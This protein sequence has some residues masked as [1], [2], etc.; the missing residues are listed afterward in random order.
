MAA[1]HVRT[2]AAGRWF[3]PSGQIEIASTPTHAAELDEDLTRTRSL[4][5]RAERIT[6]SQ[7][8]SYEPALRLPEP[9]QLI[10]RYPDE[11]YCLPYLL[12]GE[13]STRLQAAG[14]ELREGCELVSAT[15]TSAGVELRTSDGESFVADRLVCAAGRWSEQLTARLAARDGAVDPMPLL[16]CEGRDLPTLGFLGITDP[17][18]ADLRG[19][20]I[21][22][23]LSVRPEG[24]GRLMLQALDLDAAADSA[25]EP[26]PDSGI[27]REMT[28]RMTALLA[29]PRPVRLS[30]LLLGRRAIPV[31]GQTVAGWLEPDQRIYGVVTHSG[32]TLA[33]ILGD[34][35]GNEVLGLPAAELES[36]RPQR[37][38]AGEAAAS[39][40]A[41]RTPGTQ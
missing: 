28:N 34:L 22:S 7:L 24:G 25:A 4:G 2:A 15:V 16:S 33:L 8:S 29:H 9:P 21:T 3:F 35:V 23:R 36:F 27:A 11:G 6:R 30:R 1:Y 32:V 5:Y 41:P 38:A 10:V 26:G 13:L 39:F 17:V 12:L 18:P 20:V 14:G 37:F 40:P 31:D 19:V